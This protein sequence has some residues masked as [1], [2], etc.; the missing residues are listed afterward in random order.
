MESAA[1]DPVVESEDE[2]ESVGEMA[3]EMKA[4]A[5]VEENEI[6]GPTRDELPFCEICKED[7]TMRCLGCRYLFCELCFQNHK[8]VDDGCNKYEP[9][10]PP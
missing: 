4:E 6:T 1:P 7:A 10:H 5:Y 2:E 9:Y 8:D 3:E